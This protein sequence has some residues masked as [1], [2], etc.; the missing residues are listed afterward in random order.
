MT[1]EQGMKKAGARSLRPK[2]AA[3]APKGVRFVGDATQMH[4]GG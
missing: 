4:H 2:L 3:L 1:P